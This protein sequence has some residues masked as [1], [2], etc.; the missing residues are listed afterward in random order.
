LCERGCEVWWLGWVEGI[1][2]FRLHGGDR[3]GK[4]FL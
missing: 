1:G 3:Y 2:C 4:D